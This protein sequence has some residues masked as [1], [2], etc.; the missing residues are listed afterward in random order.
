MTSLLFI[1][2]LLLSILL[3]FPIKA[4]LQLIHK[5]KLLQLELTSKI[6]MFNKAN[7]N[8]IILMKNNS[9][10]KNQYDEVINYGLF[11]DS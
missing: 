1:Y 2:P 8:L 4:Y 11:S 9:N 3:F 6:N 10:I 5:T 7:D